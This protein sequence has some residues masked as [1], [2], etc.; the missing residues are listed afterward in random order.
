MRNVRPAQQRD[1]QVAPGTSRTLPSASFSAASGGPPP[2]GEGG[3]STAAAK[4][5]SGSTFGG[6]FAG[7]GAT[8]G[9]RAPAWPAPARWTALAS[10]WSLAPPDRP[11]PASTVPAPQGPAAS[12]A[13]RMALSAS[14]APAVKAPAFQ[15]S[16][17]EGWGLRRPVACHLRP[18][19]S[20]S[21][22]PRPH[23]GLLAHG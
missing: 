3:K 13:G 4:S 6:V 14:R 17:V 12:A 9:G 11:A 20:R 22:A 8:G 16:S 15:A 18:P 19:G 10:A 2:S 1:V 21:P 23:S 7:G 5:L